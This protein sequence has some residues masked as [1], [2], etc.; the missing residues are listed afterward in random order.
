VV[1]AF[2]D[3]DPDRPLIVGRVYHGTNKAPYPLPEHKTRTVLKSNSSLGGD[4]FNELRIDDKKGDE[5][6][7]IHGEKD[8]DL[9]LEEQSRTWVGNDRHLI[10]ISDE[11]ANI[12]EDKHIDVS[13]EHRDEVGGT[14][15]VNVDGDRQEKTAQ[16]WAH[17]AGQEIH[18]K[19]GQKVVLEAGA[20]LTLK[21]GGNFVRC[22]ASGVSVVGSVI[23]LNSGGA[24]GSGSG[25]SPE[26][27]KPPMEAFDDKPGED[28]KKRPEQPEDFSPAAWVLV[29]AAKTGTPFCKVC[30]KSEPA[31]KQEAPLA[32]IVA[33][34]PVGENNR[35]EIKKVADNTSVSQL[36]WSLAKVKVGEQVDL[37]FQYSGF[38]GGEKAAVSIYS[39]DSHGQKDLIETLN[40]GLEGSSGVAT[41]PWSRSKKEAEADLKKDDQQRKEPLAFR[42]TV[43]VG[44][45]SGPEPS[46]LLQ[47]TQNIVVDLLGDN[48]EKLPDNTVVELKAADGVKKTATVKD[49]IAQIEDV[50]VGPFVVYIKEIPQN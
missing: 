25:S 13:E 40:T 24:A 15:S 6:I 19:A 50:I 4:G 8:L 37:S 5:Q 16:R 1:V 14:I 11:L 9:R 41:L 49:G 27:P 3:G 10:V 32:P 28:P 21:V 42:F 38:Q 33:P 45:V 12:K 43:S 35:A 26:A 22:D 30:E 36:K 18:V 39:W 48:N 44:S 20:E 47:L 23:K 34:Q 31:A 29:E 2:V 7:F 17:E 46:G